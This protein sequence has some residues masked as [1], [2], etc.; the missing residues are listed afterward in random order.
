[1][2]RPVPGRAGVEGKQPLLPDV[3]LHGNNLL[4]TTGAAGQFAGG[5]PASYR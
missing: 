4:V 1:M 5:D 2:G 3:C